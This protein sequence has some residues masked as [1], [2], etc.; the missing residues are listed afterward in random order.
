MS[1]EDIL[2]HLLGYSKGCVAQMMSIHIHIKCTNDVYTY[3][4]AEGHVICVR[5]LGTRACTRCVKAF[6]YIMRM[7]QLILNTQQSETLQGD[8]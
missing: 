5:R 1:S 7:Y 8:M 2:K 6:E 3:K 4:S